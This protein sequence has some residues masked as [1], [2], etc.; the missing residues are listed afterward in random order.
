MKNNSLQCKRRNKLVEMKVD[1][2]VA[3]VWSEWAEKVQHEKQEEDEET[4]AHILMDIHHT[5]LHTK[6]VPKFRR[7]HFSVYLL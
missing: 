4:L 5:D 2:V 7:Y 6:Y 3:V 1:D